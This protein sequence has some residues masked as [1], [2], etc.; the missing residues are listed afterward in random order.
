MF[1]IWGAVFVFGAIFFAI[2]AR[3]ETQDWALE[4]PDM[5]EPFDDPSEAKLSDE[6]SEAKLSD[7]PS[8]EKF[9]S[10]ESFTSHL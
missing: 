7:N 10:S 3:G 9:A 6:P 1:Y 8:E 5:S 4:S 2:L